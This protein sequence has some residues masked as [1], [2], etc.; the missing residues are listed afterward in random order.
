M[1]ERLSHVFLGISY[2]KIIVFKTGILKPRVGHRVG[3]FFPLL[4]FCWFNY[5]STEQKKEKKNFCTS[6]KT[7][8]TLTI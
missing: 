1:Q 4:F 8:R 2:G 5:V 7:I 6:R 3:I